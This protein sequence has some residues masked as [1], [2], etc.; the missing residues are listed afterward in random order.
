MHNVD[1]KVMRIFNTYG[2]HMDPADGRVVSNFIMQALAQE[3]I[4]IYGSGKQ[5]RSFCYVDDLIEG[6]IALMLS[7]VGVTGPINLGNPD[8]YTLLQLAGLISSITGSSSELVF[9]PLPSDDP[10]RR[11]P[12]ISQAAQQLN[13]QP[14]TSLERGLTKTIAYFAA[15]MRRTALAKSTVVDQPQPTL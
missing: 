4:T 9:K 2:P 6:M 8:E 15:E 13:W 3:P 12:D 7:P 10:C 5:T 1:I 11:M 14:S